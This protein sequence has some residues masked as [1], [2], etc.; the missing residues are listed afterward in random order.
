M[1]KIYQSN[2]GLLSVGIADK[3]SNWKIANRG[4]IW[5]LY[6]TSPYHKIKTDLARFIHKPELP[7]I[8]GDLISDYEI[9]NDWFLSD[10][11][12]QEYYRE[13]ETL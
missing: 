9:E 1:I 3:P 12:W 7:Q 5:N 2:Q 11:T 8:V 4:G 13:G 6:N 10:K